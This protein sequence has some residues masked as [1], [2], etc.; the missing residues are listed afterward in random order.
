MHLVLIFEKNSILQ[1]C[2][3]LV[4]DMSDQMNLD[5]INCN[6][7][8]VLSFLQFISIFMVMKISF[9]KAKTVNIYKS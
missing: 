7:A 3:K 1:G 9:R 5:R 4:C 2:F 8:Q 6:V